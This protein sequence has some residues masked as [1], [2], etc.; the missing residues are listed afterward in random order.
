MPFV[1]Y[2]QTEG[3]ALV[4]HALAAQRSL[5]AINRAA[6]SGR[7]VERHTMKYRFESASCRSL[8][9]LTS[10]NMSDWNWLNVQPCVIKAA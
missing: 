4:P 5:V 1:V 10:A 9:A 3:A 2:P 8:P 6:H 7:T